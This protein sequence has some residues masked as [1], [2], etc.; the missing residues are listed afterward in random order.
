MDQ[1]PDNKGYESERES[2]EISTVFSA[3]EEHEDRIKSPKKRKI[4]TVIAAALAV[5]VLVGG[6]LAVIK[7][8]PKKDEGNTSSVDNTIT[9]ID[10]DTAKIDSVTVKNENGEFEFYK[11][12]KA[13]DSSSDTPQTDWYLKDVAPDKISTSKT[14]EI[15]SAAASIKAT[16]EITAKTFD[17]CELDSP[18]AEVSVKSE[19]LGNYMLTVGG[20][21][22]DN[23]GVYLYSSLD[24]KIYLVSGDIK[25]S[26][27][28]T[29]LELAGTDAVSPV[30]VDT[31]D[32]KYVDSSGALTGF[33]QLEVS[34]KRY[35][36]PLVITPVD[37]EEGNNVAFA[38]KVISPQKRYA[39]SEEVTSFF[40]AFSSG[41]SVSGVY[42][43]DTNAAA[44][45][46][47]GLDKPDLVLKL[48]VAGQTFT[49]KF[50]EQS[51]GFYAIYGDGISVIK[52]VSSSA[53]T[54]L[55]IEE[56]DIYN[57]IAYIRL[58]ADIKNM[59]FTSGTDVYSFD[60][61][62]NPDDE[63]EKFTVNYG[64]KS[65]KSENFQNFYMHFVNVM[66]VDFSSGIANKTPD[67]SVKITCN[68]SVV[69]YLNFYYQNATEYYCTLNNV[70]LGKVTAATYNKLIDDIK[71]VS[72]NKN[73]EV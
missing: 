9:V 16:M 61:S 21:S 47:F 48:T 4:L 10:F 71:S 57:K 49:Y 34:G 17:E 69:D 52:Q 35:A 67:L 43:L 53:A 51:D 12:V 1:F 54:F 37:E 19:E 11:L 20:V 14:S 66:L 65:I 32:S 50:A 31:T 46:Q 60:I 24:E 56:N 41:I 27:I 73:V 29:E 40:S 38:Y 58:L 62:E 25:D 72:K 59:T 44:L 18:V 45:K 23:S 26:F 64:D 28:F 39:E 42:S 3:P 70:P 8:I 7:F 63:E 5:C 30:S 22:P 68:N 13:T 2:D 15:I 55:T 36:K 6:T 33:D